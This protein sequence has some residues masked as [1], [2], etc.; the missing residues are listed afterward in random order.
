M[1]RC[2]GAEEAVC[3][4]RTRRCPQWVRNFYARGVPIKGVA[5][6]GPRDLAALGTDLAAF[7]VSWVPLAGGPVATLLQGVTNR[8][9]RRRIRFV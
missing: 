8:V 2:G 7:G 3:A 1:W 6:E 5:T 4:P 9:F